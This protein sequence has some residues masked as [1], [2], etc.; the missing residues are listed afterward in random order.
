MLSTLKRLASS[1]SKGI[2]NKKRKQNNVEF[3]TALRI[4]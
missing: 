3:H 2:V 1:G 4:W